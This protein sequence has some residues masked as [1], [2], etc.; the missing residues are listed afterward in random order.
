MDGDGASSAVSQSVKQ[1]VSLVDSDPRAEQRQQHQGGGPDKRADVQANQQTLH[2]SAAHR[3]NHHTTPRS[4]RTQH[5]ATR[6][7]P[8]TLTTSHS[9]DTLHGTRPASRLL[10]SRLMSNTAPT[11][12]IQAIYSL[13]ATAT[14]ASSS[15][16]TPAASTPASFS[17]CHR[18]AP[19][20]AHF[21]F[22]DS[23]SYSDSTLLRCEWSEHGYRMNVPH[24][25]DCSVL[26]D[27]AGTDPALV[28]RVAA[29]GY[30]ITQDIEGSGSDGTGSSKL[31]Q[32]TCH[33]VVLSTASRILRAIIHGP[34]AI[35]TYRTY[36]ASLLVSSAAYSFCGAVLVSLVVRRHDVWRSVDV[37]R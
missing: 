28:E 24:L 16:S 32:L 8:H 3:T 4:P 31:L 21:T 25:T 36:T 15:P 29:A 19:L 37:R 18:L 30:R 13:P 2:A 6:Q 1:S 7:Q 17:Q 14:S 11:P 34:S 20:P 33:R 12:S 10:L 35:R 26:I 27:T 22:P 9:P 5:P 23:G